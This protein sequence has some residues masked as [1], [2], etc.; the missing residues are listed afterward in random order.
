MPTTMPPS[1]S[2]TPL[3]T[4]VAAAAAITPVNPK[5]L[6]VHVTAFNCSRAIYAML[7]LFCAP[8]ILSEASSCMVGRLAV[9]QERS[10]LDS[11]LVGLS[12]RPTKPQAYAV[13]VHREITINAH[14]LTSPTSAFALSQVPHACD[15]DDGIYLTRCCID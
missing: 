5:C 8:L 9:L 12:L 15:A 13:A 14:A 4:A 6:T 2:T 7:T 11:R 3:V 10:L 1:S